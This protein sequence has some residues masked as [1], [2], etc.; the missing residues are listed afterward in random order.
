[1]DIYFDQ[2]SCSEFGWIKLD[3]SNAFGCVYATTHSYGLVNYY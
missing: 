1:M 2:I 3:L